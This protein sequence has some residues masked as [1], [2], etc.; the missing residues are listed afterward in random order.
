MSIMK[1]FWRLGRVGL[2]LVPFTMAADRPVSPTPFRTKV[3][4]LEQ[5]TFEALNELRRDPHGFAA[6]MKKLV[7]LFKGKKLSLGSNVW[8]D[9]QEGV[10]ALNEA[11]LAVERAHVLGTLGSSNS[12]RHAAQDLV[13]DQGRSGRTGHDGSDGSSPGDRVVRYLRMPATVGENIFYGNYG[14]SS[15]YDVIIG[16]LV[17]DGEP[18]RDH[19]RSLLNGEFKLVGVAC[20]DHP[21][22]L[23]ICVLD[24]AS[25]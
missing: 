20:G 21:K 18:T 12:L 13:N 4:A 23:Q 15:G 16:L 2:F 7:K 25:G 3:T 14:D 19:R 8:L 10:D 17:D 22:F 24:L 6:R 5:K 9:T 11:I 1:T